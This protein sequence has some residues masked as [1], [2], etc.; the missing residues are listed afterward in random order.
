MS[1]RATE[2]AL[3]I[4]Y[5]SNYYR[6]IVSG[7]ARYSNLKG[8]RFY[9]SRGFPQI[10]K[11]DLKNWEGGGVI[12]RLT[13][14]VIADLQHRGIPAVNVKSD[15]LDLPVASV[16]MD[17]AA[18]G[19]QAAEFFIE[20]G[21]RSFAATAW[22]IKGAS[23][24]LKLQGFLQTLEKHGYK[25]I[26]LEARKELDRLDRVLS[27]EKGETVGIF[28]AEDFLGRMVIEAC[29][30]LGLRVPEDVA[31]IGVD[32]SP[33]ICEMVKPTM[34]SVELGAERVGYQAA[35]LLDELMQGGSIPEKP[36][37]IAPE[38][39]VERQSTDILEIDDELVANALRF[40][41]DHASEPLTVSEVT[42]ALFCNR[43]VLEKKFKAEVGRTLHEEIR[44]SRIKRACGLLRESDMLV[45]VLAEACG[46]SSRE[47]FNAAFRR[48][49]GKTPSAYRKEYRFG[50]KN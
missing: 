27:L 31:V 26:V 34:S 21:V 15:Y 42:G 45:E 32:N 48:E 18:I 10:S 47:R 1:D 13:P 4:D 11:Q 29:A 20:K 6:S 8:W 7:V 37:M 36:V 3:C 40:I 23:G 35:S 28:A 14:D 50:S 9:T 39:V 44:R 24:D 25:A 30:D 2:I 41:N 33:F 5:N 17:N 46:Y 22:S 12:G 19:R 38:R 43:R 16:L 49:T